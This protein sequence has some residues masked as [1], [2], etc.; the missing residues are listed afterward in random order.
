MDLCAMH[1]DIAANVQSVRDELREKSNEK[2]KDGM[3]DHEH[4]GSEDRIFRSGLKQ[5]LEEMKAMI[6]KLTA[7]VARLEQFQPPSPTRQL[8][9][10]PSV[11]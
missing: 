3:K 7:D 4:H 9:R 8:R 11:S 1:P 5:D 2:A 6:L 10:L